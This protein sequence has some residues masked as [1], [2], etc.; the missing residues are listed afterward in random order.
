MYY[1]SHGRVVLATT[2][3]KPGE[4]GYDS[5]LAAKRDQS[6]RVLRRAELA[7]L[8]WTMLVPAIGAYLLTYVRSL[9]SDPDRYINRSVISLF[10]IATA[11]K[12]TLHFAKLVKNSEQKQGFVCQTRRSLYRM[13]FLRFALPPRVRGRNGNR[14]FCPCSLLHSYTDKCGIPTQ[15]STC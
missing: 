9:L 4:E 10:A 12:P 11:V 14:S 2:E 1:A 7:A 8:L 3:P 13:Y 15:R 6:V 5:E